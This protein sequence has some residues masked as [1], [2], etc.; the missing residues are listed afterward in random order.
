MAGGEGGESEWAKALAEST[1]A[2]PGQFEKDMKMKGLLG[3]NKGKGNTK[4]TANS[5]LIKWL[6]EEGI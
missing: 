5:N 6:E 1:S 3:G 4:L 2:V